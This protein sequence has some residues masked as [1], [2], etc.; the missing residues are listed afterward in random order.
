MTRYIGNR[1]SRQPLAPRCR[2]VTSTQRAQRNV[3][4]CI[5]RLRLGP[6]AA[7]LRRPTVHLRCSLCGQRS[8]L[9]CL[10]LNSPCLTRANRQERNCKIRSDGASNLNL[11][12]PLEAQFSNEA[13]QLRSLALELM[14]PRG[15]VHRRRRYIR[16]IQKMKAGEEVGRP[17]D[18]YILDDTNFG[19]CSSQ[20]D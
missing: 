7:P 13:L 18:S 16:F 20:P 5:Y 6:A 15:S 8:E 11:R 9:S 3:S 4:I 1:L 10:I 19:D 14:P 12:S 2:Q 17:I